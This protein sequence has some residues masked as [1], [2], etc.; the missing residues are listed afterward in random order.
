[1]QDVLFK[2]LVT[3]F[4]IDCFIAIP[5]IHIH[6]FPSH[7]WASKP[8]GLHAQFQLGLSKQSAELK[9]SDSFPHMFF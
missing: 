6:F 9:N 4:S 2:T 8:D 5:G 3:T 7:H 1:M